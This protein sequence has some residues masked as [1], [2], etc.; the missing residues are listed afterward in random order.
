MRERHDALS[1]APN[2]SCGRGFRLCA[3]A[4]LY[5]A[6]NRSERLPGP[7]GQ[8]SQPLAAERWCGLT[9]PTRAGRK[10]VARVS[11]LATA[12]QPAAPCEASGT[13]DAVQS[14]PPRAVRFSAVSLNRRPCSWLCVP[15]GGSAHRASS[16]LGV[17][18]ALAAHASLIAVPTQDHPAL[19]IRALLELTT[20]LTVCHRPSPCS[21]CSWPAP[22]LP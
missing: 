13:R 2:A 1:F 16:C 19:G 22:C 9:T 4:S 17:R 14:R 15:Y 3:A 12:Q 5:R 7:L 21:C 6:V 8:D 11:K 18:R 10:A 20:A